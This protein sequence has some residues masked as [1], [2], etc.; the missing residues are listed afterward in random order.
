QKR[1]S[2]TTDTTADNDVFFVYCQEGSGGA[3]IPDTSATI[4]NAISDEVFNG[5]FSPMAC[6]NA[7]AGYIGMQGK[8]LTLAFASSDGN[9][10]I[11]IGT[12]AMSADIVLSSPL[13]TCGELQFSCR[14]IDGS[15]NPD[16]LYE[17]ES[18]GVTY[19][20]F[21]QEVSFK[22]AKAESV[23]YKLIVKEIVS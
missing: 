16:A 2:D 22:Y 14:G 1:C 21:V 9:S 11:V 12:Q 20:G 19:R 3:W 10:D 4:T 18:G 23:K 5:V 8:P 17:V 15:F 6:V 13:L 7:N